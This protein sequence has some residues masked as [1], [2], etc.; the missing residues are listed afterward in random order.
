MRHEAEHSTKWLSTSQ[1]V[2][3]ALSESAK[4]DQ[5]VRL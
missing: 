5:I 2:S 4:G 3:A 1:I